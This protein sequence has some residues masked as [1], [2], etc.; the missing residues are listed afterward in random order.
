MPKYRADAK[1]LGENDRQRLVV[2]LND[3]ADR[4]TLVE[5]LLIHR[6]ADN[7]RAVRVV[8][9]KNFCFGHESCLRVLLQG[10]EGLKVS[11]EVYG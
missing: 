7:D 10:R 8:A 5:V 1:L 2:G 9:R 4:L 6:E 3:Y 11:V